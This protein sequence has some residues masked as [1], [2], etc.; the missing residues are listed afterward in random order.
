[1]Y[2]CMYIHTHTY[3]F[4]R[5]DVADL[6]QPISDLLL[7]E[8]KQGFEPF[9]QSPEMFTSPAAHTPGISV[10]PLPEAILVMDFVKLPITNLVIPWASPRTFH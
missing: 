4:S 8:Q 2:V 6:K 3:T 9:S 7:P 10:R 5:D 1:M